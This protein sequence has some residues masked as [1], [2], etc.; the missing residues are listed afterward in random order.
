MLSASLWLMPPWQGQNTR[1]AGTVAGAVDGVV[2]DRRR[3]AR[4]GMAPRL[5]GRLDPVHQ[6]RIERRRRGAPELLHADR[7]AALR[8]Q[9]HRPGPGSAPRIASSCSVSPW[10]VSRLNQTRPGVML[11]LDGSAV[12]TPTVA[13]PR[14]SSAPTASRAMPSRDGDQ[15]R[16]G[17]HGVAPPV[18]GAAGMGLLA[19]HGD[20]VPDLRQRPVDHADGQARILQ[21]LALLDM[22]LEIGADRRAGPPDPPRPAS[23]CAAARRRRRGRRGPGS[24]GCRPPGRCPWRRRCRSSAARSARPPRC[25]S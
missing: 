11:R 3:H 17:H 7:D 5:G 21:A 4:P 20:L 13:R 12:S 14:S 19:Q 15:R 2:V 22:Q 6:D 1:A 18:H 25:T 10:R 16:R 23:R 24:P 8:R 9:R